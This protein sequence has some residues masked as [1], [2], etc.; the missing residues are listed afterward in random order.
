[1]EIIKVSATSP[2]PAVA[3]A[4][5]SV[6]HEYHCAEVQA[7]GAEASNQAM[8]AIVLATGYLRQ[9]GI[10]MTFVRQRKKVLVENKHQMLVRFMIEATVGSS[11]SPSNTLVKGDLPRV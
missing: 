7:I 3:G 5:A 4:I 1:M 9:E 11:L 6:V 8:E 10:S 2:P